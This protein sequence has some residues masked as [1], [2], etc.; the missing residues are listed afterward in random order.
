[1]LISGQ[2][3]TPAAAGQTVSL[4]QQLAGVGGAF[5]KIAQTHTDTHG[6]YEFANTEQNVQTNRSWFVNA[7]GGNTAASRTVFEPVSALVTVSASAVS[8]VTGQP[9]VFTGTVT[10]NHGGE[11]VRLQQQTGSSAK[12]Q[13]VGTALLGSG[14]QF[15]ISHKFRLAGV[16][17]VRVLFPGDV[18]NAS[19]ASGPITIII[20]QRQIP[21]FTVLTSSPLI[22]YGQAQPVTI[23]GV[24]DQAG[25]SNQPQ[26]NTP[27]TLWAQT[28]GHHQFSAIGDATTHNDGSY[29][30]TPPAPTANTVYQVRTTVG[31]VRHTAPLLVGVSDA[32]TL[33]PSPSTTTAAT[34][35]R[36]VT[37]TG[38]VRPD[39]PGQKV[40]LQSTAR[41]GA[42]HNVASSSIQPGG[43]FTF[44]WTFGKAG[45]YQFRGWV[46]DGQGNIGGASAP[47]TIQV[48]PAT[49]AAGLPATS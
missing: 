7:A 39:K 27:V 47:V 1:V 45:T 22:D 34:A 24:L 23:T 30:F 9:V 41:D 20:Q 25:S 4:Y 49:S 19:G 35:G 46:G 6:L 43:N 32:V 36:T 44:S 11:L 28:A 38:T 5:V 18:R 21:G 13:T 37:F 10:P 29:T 2:L 16:R 8:G 40:Y 31:G 3:R 26:A 17:S 15:S 33:L 48:S 12:W 14:S 42:W